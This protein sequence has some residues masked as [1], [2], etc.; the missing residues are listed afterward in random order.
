MSY[1]TYCELLSVDENSGA[2]HSVQN[3]STAGAYGVSTL[4]TPFGIYLV[5]SNQALKLSYIMRFNTAQRVF[6]SWQNISTYAAQ[7]PESFERNGEYFIALPNFGAPP[8]LNVSV[9]YKLQPSS[10]M[11]FLNQS[12]ATNGSSF[13]KPWTWRDAYYLTIVENNAGFVDTYVYNT[14]TY[15]YVRSSVL[16]LSL[17]APNSVDVAVLA[18]VPVMVVSQYYSGANVYVWNA[19]SSVF[20]Y[21]QSLPAPAHAWRAPVFM[22]VNGDTYLAFSNNM[23]K[24]CRS[25]FALQSS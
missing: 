18:D 17:Y 15:Q 21:S 20:L 24:W 25:A 19:L 8:A 12:F 6:E 22:S 3:I 14:S 13:M 10:G 11:F 9:I 23:Y 4:S 2:A 16:R 1:S 5:I 7:P